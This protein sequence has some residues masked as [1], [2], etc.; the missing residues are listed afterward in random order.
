MSERALGPFLGRQWGGVVGGL[1]TLFAPETARA[2]LS[3]LG[4][5]CSVFT[6]FRNVTFPSCVTYSAFFSLRRGRK[7]LTVQTIAMRATSAKAIAS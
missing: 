2:I 6:G 3:I 4:S 5:S 1:S 7:P